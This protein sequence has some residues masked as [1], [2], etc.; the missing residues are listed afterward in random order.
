MAA[1]K[2]RAGQVPT[3]GMTRPARKPRARAANILCP[4]S[5]QG[6]N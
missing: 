6:Q 4:V 5:R 3:A 2:Q 1:S